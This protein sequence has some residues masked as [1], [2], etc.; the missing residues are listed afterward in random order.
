MSELSAESRT[1]LEFYAGSGFD[2]PVS[3]AAREV[4]ALVDQLQA[5]LAEALQSRDRW[6][7]GAGICQDELADA[8][9]REAR[10]RELLPDLPA[11]ARAE[12][13]QAL[14]GPERCRARSRV[15]DPVRCTHNAGHA[16]IPDSPDKLPGRVW[17]HAAPGVWWTA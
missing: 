5:E 1:W 17:D 4:L 2:S 3:S 12:V 11:R 10:V 16:P 15:D 13:V 7:Q 8:Q 6:S 14:D 9:R